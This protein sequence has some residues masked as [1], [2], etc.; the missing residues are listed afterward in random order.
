MRVL[1]FLGWLFGGFFIIL[2]LFF[3]DT[4][5]FF[6][7]AINSLSL[8]L[9]FKEER[10]L[11]EREEELSSFSEEISVIAQNMKGEFVSLDDIFS[12]F[13]NAIR[14]T[15]AFF[16][17]MNDV[18][19]YNKVYKGPMESDFMYMI[20]LRKKFQKSE[21]IKRSNER[22]TNIKRNRKKLVVIENFLSENEKGKIV[23]AK[24]LGYFFPEKS[25]YSG[26]Y[27]QRGYHVNFAALQ[28]TIDKYKQKVAVAKQDHMMLQLHNSIAKSQKELNMA[29]ASIQ[30]Q[31]MDDRSD[32]ENY[33]HPSGKK[34]DKEIDYLEK[35]FQQI[36]GSQYRQTPILE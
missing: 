36:R 14:T 35:E 26:I 8:S 3:L 32:D 17:Y 34:G 9:F 28:R 18:E 23:N 13:I 11:Q 19:F 20:R 21:K 4:I 25:E 29:I 1:I 24:R 27:F 15:K 33:N 6:R 10:V 7:I 2:Y 31:M 16:E 5:D 30:E 12:V 22:T